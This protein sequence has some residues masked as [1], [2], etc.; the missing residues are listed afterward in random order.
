FSIRLLRYGDMPANLSDDTW[1]IEIKIKVDGT[2]YTDEPWFVNE[3]EI[4]IQRGSEIFKGVIEGLN[5]GKEISFVITD[6]SYGTTTY[7][8]KIDAFGLDD[9]PHDWKAR[10]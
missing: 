5:A 2:V 10:I 9:I 1:D 8:F 7:Q 3:S 6:S 4:Y